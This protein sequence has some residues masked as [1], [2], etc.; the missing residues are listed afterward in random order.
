AGKPDLPPNQPAGYGDHHVKNGP[1]RS[2]QPIRW[3]PRWLLQA[4]VP[5]T[6]PEE[7]ACHGREDA[8]RNETQ[9]REPGRGFHDH[10]P[11]TNSDS[12]GRPRSTRRDHSVVCPSKCSSEVSA[13]DLV[14]CTV[15]SR[16]SGGA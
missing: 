3:S 9:Q 1:N 2:K 15:P 7:G 12:Q 16:C 5:V 4:L 8:G 14:A 13:S 6:R 10:L 11:Q